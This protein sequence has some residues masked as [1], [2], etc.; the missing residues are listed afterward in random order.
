M[1]NLRE[2]LLIL[3]DENFEFVNF[4]VPIIYICQFSQWKLLKLISKDLKFWSHD[5]DHLKPNEAN[6]HNS[7]A[8][9]DHCNH[10]M[11]VD[12]EVKRW[13]FFIQFQW[14]KTFSECQSRIDCDAG[15][16]DKT[17]NRWSTKEEAEETESWLSDFECS[18]I[19]LCKWFLI[20]EI[21]DFKEVFLILNLNRI[22]YKIMKRNDRER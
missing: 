16:S 19:I 9:Q 11:H 20:E 13:I 4:R 3:F 17:K 14:S 5:V 21:N 8:C 15:Q 2:K 22:K 12:Q 6:S 10:C 18:F 7:C 1:N